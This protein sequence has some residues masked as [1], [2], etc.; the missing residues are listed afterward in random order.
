MK[1]E[2]KTYTSA[3]L[4]FQGQ[5]RR[6]VKEFSHI[7]TTLRPELVIDLFGGSGLLAH[8]AKRAWPKARVVYNDYD[9]YCERMEHIVDT[10]KMIREFR[11]LLRDVPNEHRITGTLRVAILQRLKEADKC[12]YV[13]WIT[14]SSSLHFSM[15]YA[16]CLASFHAE[17]LFNNVRCNDYTVDGYLDGLEVVRFDYRELCDQ[18][19]DVPGALFIADPPYLSTDT[20]TYSSSSYWHLKDYLDVLTALAGLNYVYFTSNK[21]HIIELCE[22]LDTNE[23]KVRNIFKGA[24]IKTVFSHAT[25]KAGYTDIMLYK[26]NLK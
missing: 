22:W 11:E 15:K 18:Y 13:D 12:G 23:G 10:N 21:S 20:S 19:R 2:L 8:T 9:N 14:L 17:S 5:K 4:P 7:I 25:G 24:S 3:P 26:L 6:Y 1:K 16:M